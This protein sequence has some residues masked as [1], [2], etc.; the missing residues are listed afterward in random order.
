MKI[1]QDDDNTDVDGTPNDADGTAS[2][3]HTDELVNVKIPTT[4]AATTTALV[5]TQG[6][7][8]VVKRRMQLVSSATV[9]N[10]N[11]ETLNTTAPVVVGVAGQNIRSG[12]QAKYRKFE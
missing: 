7:K 1:F 10:N 3:T 12:N 5:P 11:S 6:R 2:S 8:I 4:K 9:G